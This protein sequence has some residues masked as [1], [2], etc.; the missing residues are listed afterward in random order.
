MKVLNRHDGV[1]MDDSNIIYIGRP[2][3]FG[4]PFQMHG[5]DSRKEVIERYRLWFDGQMRFYPQ[6]RLRVLQLRGHDLACWCAP[7]PCHG[8]VI[9]DWLNKHEE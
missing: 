9:I 3:M 7:K 4:N 6:F 1:Q 5:E 8:D 2:G